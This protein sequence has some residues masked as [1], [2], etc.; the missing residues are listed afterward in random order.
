MIHIH[1]ELNYLTNDTIILLNDKYL[2]EFIN[3]SNDEIVDI[4]NLYT[5]KINQ[6]TYYEKDIK[7]SINN[8]HNVVIF[9]VSL[10]E[11]HLYK[12]IINCLTELYDRKFRR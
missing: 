1:D 4:I 2:R 5:T 7:V 10:K 8:T 12:L 9:R 6:I 11:I 3:I